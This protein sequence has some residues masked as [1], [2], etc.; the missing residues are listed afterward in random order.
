MAIR[1]FHLPFFAPA[2]Y[3]RAKGRRSLPAA[4]ESSYHNFYMSR[5]GRRNGGP[6]PMKRLLTLV[7]AAMLALSLTACGA[8]SETG[9]G[10]PRHGGPAP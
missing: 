10:P 7:L 2:W 6:M 1:G 3:D 9:S 5:L 4:P 8:Q